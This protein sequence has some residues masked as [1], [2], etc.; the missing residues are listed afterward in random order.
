MKERGFRRAAFPLLIAVASLPS[1]APTARL[2]QFRGFADA[3][4]AYVNASESLLEQ[5]GDAAI[6]A[7]S[8]VLVVARER[9]PDPGERTRSLLES[10]RLL[11]ERLT[12]LEE[13]RRHGQLLRSYFLALAAL[14]D[15]EPT[16][17]IAAAT[18]EIVVALGDL[19]AGIR[20][21]R[22]GGLQVGDL[23]SGATEIA[24]ADFRRVA[25]ERELRAH[26]ST[27]ASELDLQRA[28][29]EAVAAQMRADLEIVLAGLE[30]TE[31]VAPF[32]AGRQLPRRW[33][34]SRKEI[35]KADRA[36]ESADAGA[37]AAAALETSFVALVEDRLGLA[38]LQALI[39][40]IDRLV[41]LI[42]QVVDTE[43][44]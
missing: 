10:N 9:L 27:I 3:G 37:V 40:D 30:A 25:L 39:G 38:D 18:G 4:V 26:A 14:A 8:H 13:L 33:W 43:S 29:M 17:G 34:T 12:L 19:E 36:I 7:D 6:D 20:T 31:V 35:L 5:A 22:I 15:G 32:R 1:C 41:E 42:G 16:A 2:D 24:V 28:A 23:A 21:A 11:R 44:G